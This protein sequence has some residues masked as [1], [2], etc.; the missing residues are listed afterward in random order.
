MHINVRCV[1]I[2]LRSYGGHKVFQE[3]RKDKDR[4]RKPGTEASLW[5]LHIKRV[6]EVHPLT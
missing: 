5:F 2:H 4:I 3:R 6:T 1:W